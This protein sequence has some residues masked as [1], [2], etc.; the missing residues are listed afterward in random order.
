ML[1]VFGILVGLALGLTGGGGSLLAV[2]ILVYLVGLDVS[3]A[4]TM[5]LA[6]VATTAAAGA[7]EAW[8]SRLLMMRAS[9]FFIAGGLFG[10]PV[11]VSLTTY[12]SDNI[13]MLSFGALMMV[14]AASMI[15]RSM[16]HPEDD[17]VVRADLD[18]GL[19][20]SGPACRMESD[21][22]LRITAACS[23]A[24]A[25]GGVVTGLLSGLFGVGGGFLIVPALMFITQMDIRRAVASSLLVITAIGYIGLVSALV[26]G[27][28]LDPAIVAMFTL[29]GLLGMFLGRLLARRIAGASLQRLFAV[30]TAVLGLFIVF[31]N[32]G[33]L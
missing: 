32:T 21:G 24:L 27:R 29:G 20:G 1:L 30:S 11:G 13:L 15:L 3:Q 5:S 12:I 19:I 22:K 28:D 6:V 26:S 31:S 2:P 25:V 10:A 33:G 18:E 4:V 7:V 9:L 8:R 14:V 23:M 17:R 16:M